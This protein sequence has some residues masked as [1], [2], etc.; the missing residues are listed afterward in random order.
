MRVAAAIKRE[1]KSGGQ[2]GAA[3]AEGSAPGRTRSHLSPQKKFRPSG[4]FFIFSNDKSKVSDAILNSADAVSSNAP[5]RSEEISAP[6]ASRCWSCQGTGVRMKKRPRDSASGASRGAAPEPCKLC[7]GSGTL[8]RAAPRMKP[9]AFKSFEGWIGAGPVIPGTPTL[10]AYEEICCLTGHWRIIQRTDSHRYSTDDLV[11][12]W[13]AWRAGSA[14]RAVNLDKRFSTLACD[15]GCGLGSVLLATAWLH[16]QSV[17]VGAEAQPVRAELAERNVV[18]NGL[19]G[20]RARVVRGDLRD[21]TTHASLARAALDLAAA[22]DGGQSKNES[23]PRDAACD[24]FDI[25]TGTPPYFDIAAGGL[26][27]HE[28]SARCLF[29]YRGGIEA[30]AA[31]V[32]ALLSRTGVGAIC[33]TSL[34]LHRAYAAAAAARLRVV[35]RVD[36]IPRAGKPP[37]FFVLIVQRDDA[38][39]APAS[40]WAQAFGELPSSHL[41]YADMRESPYET[42]FVAGRAAASARA[43]AS[44]SASSKAAALDASPKAK[45]T[46][47]VARGAHVDALGSALGEGGEAVRVVCVRDERG[48]RTEDYSRLLWELGKPS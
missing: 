18:L 41:P 45:K 39:L 35:A 20:R 40:L 7:S 17:C 37:L 29:E 2:A 12:A 38:P 5:A 31:A 36:V 42:A 11:T 28:E 21:S 15:I 27:P 32:R 48:E 1:G 3:R 30:Y 26:P 19:A 47:Q 8:S 9:R 44:S 25:V 13:A 14:L 23:V 43:V 24:V 10:S 16:P 34:A 33:E 4:G 46:R 22:I 6:A